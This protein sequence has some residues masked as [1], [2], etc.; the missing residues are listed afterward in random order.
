FALVSTTAFAGDDHH[1][2]HNLSMNTTNADSNNCEDHIRISSDDLQAIAH[3][4]ESATLANQPLT[5]KASQ[6]GGIHVRNWDKNEISVKLCRAAAARTQTE[7]NNALS[8]IHLNNSGNRISVD[9]PDSS[10]DND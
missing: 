8:Q 9:G 7:A 2:G 1:W 3:S 10:S 4:E 5:V 6:N